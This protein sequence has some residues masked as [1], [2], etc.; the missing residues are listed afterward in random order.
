MRLVACAVM[1]LL[2][3]L[4]VNGELLL[5]YSFSE[6]NVTTTGRV[7]R[8]ALNGGS[9][10][11]GHLDL[12]GWDAI[13]ETELVAELSAS[14][15]GCRFGCLQELDVFGDDRARTN[16]RIMGE[17]GRAGVARTYETL[18]ELGEHDQMTWSGWFNSGDELLSNGATL[19]SIPGQIE[20]K[21]GAGPFMGGL[22]VSLWHAGNASPE[23]LV[24]Q[25][26]SLDRPDSDWVFWSVTYNQTA[27]N[28]HIQVHRGTADENVSLVSQ[29]SFPD[30]GMIGTPTGPMSVGNVGSG[31]LAFLRPFV[32]QMD[33]L[34]VHNS[35]LS[36]Y[37]LDP[38]RSQNP[39]PLET[40]PN[41]TG[42]RPD[43]VDASDR[44]HLIVNW[45]GQLPRYTGEK[46][47]ADGDSDRDGD[48]DAI[49]QL[50]VA[51]E[52][53]NGG[54][55][56]FKVNPLHQCFGLDSTGAQLRY[57][58]LSGNVAIDATNALG[59][60]GGFVLTDD[61]GRLLPDGFSPPFIDLEQTP[62][63][64]SLR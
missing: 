37:E 36:G 27:E 54:F 22:D 35:A 14:P 44:T 25:P 21:G 59:L 5:E 23:R 57:D 62:I 45:T 60:V 33:N 16:V 52:Q 41:F 13:H 64:R 53:C 38:L 50:A 3:A 42:R 12:L 49:D 58:V 31:D 43:L 32:G 46:T 24:T 11:F 63:Q 8:V 48:V 26:F 17:G 1:L 20:I 9:V 4:P 34:R 61:K 28:G 19:L 18:T 29:A 7:D 30:A 15:P 10:R 55:R 39:E 2:T 56:Q 51:A 6:S 47:F 40:F